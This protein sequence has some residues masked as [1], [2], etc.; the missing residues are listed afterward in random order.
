MIALDSADGHYLLGA[1]LTPHNA[2]LGTVIH[3][4]ADRDQM[5]AAPRRFGGTIDSADATY[6]IVAPP[7]GHRLG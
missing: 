3:H 1:I 5:V 4:C 2:A 7:G 6:A